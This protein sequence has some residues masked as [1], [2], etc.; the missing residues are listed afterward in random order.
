MA[1][2]SP[3]QP[4]CVVS[5]GYSEYLLPMPAAMKIAE[6]MAKAV[7]VKEAFALR[8]STYTTAGPVS[9]EV[10]V[11][12]SHQIRAADPSDG[13]DSDGDGSGGAEVRRMGQQ[14]LALAAPKGR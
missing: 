7:K 8:G 4:L 11:V 6:L 12:Q 14:P 10:K 13:D 1:T 3:A 2:K 5:I 9:V